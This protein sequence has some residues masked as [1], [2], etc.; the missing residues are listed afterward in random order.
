MYALCIYFFCTDT[1]HDRLSMILP[2]TLNMSRTPAG[3]SNFVLFEFKMHSYER[4]KCFFVDKTD[5]NDDAHAS[6][7]K[8]PIA[9][10]CLWTIFIAFQLSGLCWNTTERLFEV[11]WCWK[12]LPICF[13]LARQWYFNE[14]CADKVQKKE[15]ILKK[16]CS[17]KNLQYRLRF[18]CKSVINT[19]CNT[20]CGTVAVSGAYLPIRK[21]RKCVLKFFR[22]FY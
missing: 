7:I 12:K 16:I 1:V 8:L 14:N 3:I 2:E 10:K 15:K 13:P 17:V 6:T 22:S 19:P 18:D 5:D 20:L 11:I 9:I 21:V 4:V